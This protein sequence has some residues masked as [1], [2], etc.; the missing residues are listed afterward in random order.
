[1]GGTG[2]AEIS[3]AAQQ[4]VGSTAAGVEGAQQVAERKAEE[5]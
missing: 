3:R 4:Q 5:K 1:M 2:V